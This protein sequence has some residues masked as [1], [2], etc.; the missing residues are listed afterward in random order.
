MKE[1][2]FLLPMQRIIGGIQIQNDLPRRLAPLVATQEMVDEKP[3]ALL[4]IV[5]DLL[6]PTLW[7]YIGPAALKSVQRALTRKGL[8]F[9]LFPFAFTTLHI[10]TATERSNQGVIP[11]LLKTA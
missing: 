3:L 6:V 9:V 5:A 7:T 2:P 10:N 1:T 4:G 8:P 11:Q